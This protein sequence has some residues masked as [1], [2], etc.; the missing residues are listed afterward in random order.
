MDPRFQGIWKLALES[1]TEDAPS[2]TD[3]NSRSAEV[4]FYAFI[5]SI[6]FSGAK[7][8]KGSDGE[9]RKGSK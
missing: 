3:L 2:E 4:A 7:M 1:M 5:C 9:N 6:S 8:A